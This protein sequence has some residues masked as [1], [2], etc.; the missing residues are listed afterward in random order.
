MAFHLLLPRPSVFEDEE[1]PPS[2][3]IIEGK[4]KHQCLASAVNESHTNT[5]VVQIRIWEPGGILADCFDTCE[6]IWAAA[7]PWTAR[8]GEEVGQPQSLN[9]L[10][11]VDV[12]MVHRGPPVVA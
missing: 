11:C 5:T 7:L 3:Y 2:A 12:L 4:W 9:P 6:W 1:K 10:A 8:V